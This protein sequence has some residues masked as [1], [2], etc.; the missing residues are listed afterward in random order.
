MTT[1]YISY[2]TII[3]VIQN[4]DIYVRTVFDAITTVDLGIMGLNMNQL[5]LGLI[6]EDPVELYHYL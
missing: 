2:Y 5:Q 4:R 3:Y 1:S 6:R